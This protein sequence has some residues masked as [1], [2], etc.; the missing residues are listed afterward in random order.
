V[1]RRCLTKRTDLRLRKCLMASEKPFLRRPISAAIRGQKCELLTSGHL[2]HA[3]ARTPRTIRAWQQMNL[4]PKAPFVLHPE[5][6]RNRRWLW[7]SDFVDAMVEIAE[8]GVIGTRLDYRS[9]DLF[10]RMVDDAEGQHIL[11]LL[12]E[13]VTR[14][15]PLVSSMRGL[16]RIFC[17]NDSVIAA[18]C[19]WDRAFGPSLNDLVQRV[20]SPQR[21]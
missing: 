8:S 1:H 3:V 16:G 2:A 9:W 19:A 13:G 6:F 14:P 20:Q 5:S 4:L 21:P 15:V 10:E 7:P 18:T 17:L 11:P 12:G